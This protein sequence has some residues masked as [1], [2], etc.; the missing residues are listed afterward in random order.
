MKQIVFTLDTTG[1][2][3]P[4]LTQARRNIRETVRRL[5]RE[6]SDLEIAII[7]H[8]DYCDAGRTYVTKT[9]D[10][11]NNEDK[12]VKFVNSVEATGGGDSEECY[13]LVL[14]EARTKLSWK[15][16]DTK[17]V[18]L[19][20]DDIPHDKNYYDNK[21]RIDWRNELDL[22]LEAKIQ[23]YGVQA[24]RRSHATYFYQEIANKTNGIHLN[25]DQ[26]SHVEDL[27]LAVTFKQKGEDYLKKFEEEV[28][29]KGRM[30]RSLDDMF[31]RLY[32]RA[33]KTSIV[34]DKTYGD[35]KLTRLPSKRFAPTSLKA[36]HPARFQVLYVDRDR[37][38]MDF[39][40]DHGLTFQKGRG[41][42][43]LTKSVKVQ[44]YKEIVLQD[45]HTGDFYNGEAARDL[46][47]LPRDA[48]AQ[49]KPVS[50]D[51]YKVFIQSTSNNRKLLADTDF[52]YEVDA[53]LR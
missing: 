9:L 49:L 5:F 48:D 40:Q 35:V 20:G 16:G 30:N 41:F 7:A 24:L 28:S 33:P 51:K 10:F 6:L 26:F 36:V 38:I 12:I 4:C 39:V 15:A 32:G 22:L 2:M 37:T 23:V 46:V 29:G 11:T 43:E 34:K 1:S 27:I 47:G 21:K 52:L 14:H 13:E 3:Y 19:I 42:Y 18:V 45:R 8:G 31:D 17:V 44:S 25:L 50:L 53:S